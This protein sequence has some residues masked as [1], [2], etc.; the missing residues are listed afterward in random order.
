MHSSEGE[1]KDGKG[2][3]K[4]ACFQ[5]LAFVFL[6]AAA[7]QGRCQRGLEIRNEPMPRRRRLCEDLCDICG[8]NLE[9]CEESTRPGVV[10]CRL[11]SI[12]HCCIVSVM[13]IPKTR[14]GQ[15]K[16]SQVCVT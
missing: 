14:A 9:L 6:K 11:L 2:S 4:I 12:A 1:Q 15:P 5:C 3:T 13:Q 7:P 10:T 8:I 16:A